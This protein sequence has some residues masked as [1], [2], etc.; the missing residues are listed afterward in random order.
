MGRTRNTHG[1]EEECIHGFGEKTR[2]IE[3]LG[4]LALRLQNNIKM[5]LRVLESSGMD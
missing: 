5:D 1:V 2:R 3:P 4:K